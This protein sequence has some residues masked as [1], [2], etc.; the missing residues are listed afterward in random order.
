M[1]SSLSRLNIHSSAGAVRRNAPYTLTKKEATIDS[2]WPNYPGPRSSRT[3]CVPCRQVLQ[4]IRSRSLKCSPQFT[5]SSTFEGG[6]F[7]EHNRQLK[8]FLMFSQVALAIVPGGLQIPISCKSAATPGGIILPSKNTH[9]F[10][11]LHTL[12]QRSSPPSNILPVITRP[13]LGKPA[14]RCAKKFENAALRIGTHLRCNHF[15][16]KI[17]SSYRIAPE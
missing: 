10:C 8:H 2:G 1:E 15:A 7:V 12:S 13:I 3:S 6:P 17:S 11:C 16:R 5:N 4:M 9:D 14:T